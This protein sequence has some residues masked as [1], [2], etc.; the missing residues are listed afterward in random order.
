MLS[1]VIL[2]LRRFDAQNTEEEARRS[3]LLEPRLHVTVQ[4]FKCET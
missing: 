2:T 4:A 1:V 3:N